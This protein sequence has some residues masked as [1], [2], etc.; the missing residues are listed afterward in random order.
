M[1]ILAV[2]TATKTCSVA[3]VDGESPLSEITL[4]RE[5]THSKHL[6]EM[7][8]TVVR[9][10][11]LTISDIDGFAVTKG[12]GSFT[13]LRIGISSVKG[14]AA[15]SG[16]PIVGISTLDVLAFQFSLY[17]YPIC[18]LLDARRGEVYFSQFIFKGGILADKTEEQVLS[19]EKAVCEIKKPC[20][21]VGDGAHVYKKIIKDTIG[22]LAHFICPSINLISASSLAHLSIK[23][24][25][26][27]DTDDVSEFVPH[28]IRKSD[29]ELKKEKI[30]KHL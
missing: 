5:Q 6:M 17:P 21:F 23:R 26:E 14:L 29:A 8:D 15:A 9:L 7:I 25:M 13:G 20:L 1:K 19:P 18:V 30:N 28:Y 16:K 10:S 22:E 27:N 4:A 3:I 12:P 24:F 2:D 11:G